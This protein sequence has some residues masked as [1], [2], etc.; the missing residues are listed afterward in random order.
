MS[1]ARDIKFI[2]VS[3]LSDQKKGTIFRA[4]K[5]VIE[6]YKGK[7]HV[8]DEMAFNEYNNPVHTILADNE[9]D[10]LRQEVEKCGTRMNITA[11]NEHVPE[12]ERQNRVI[13][14]RARAIIQTLPYKNLPR[15]IQIG[16]IY[17]VVYW[18]NNIPK[19]GQDYSPRDLVFGEQKLDYNNICKMP[20]GSYVQVH[21][22]L[23]IT[24]T[25]EARTIGAIDLGPTGNAEGTHK[26][27]SLKTGEILVRRKWNELPV[28]SDV[29]DRLKELTTDQYR[30][31]DDIMEQC[32]EQN[33]NENTDNLENNFE[34]S[35]E[36]SIQSEQNNF[37]KMKVLRFLMMSVVK[38]NRSF[39]S[40]IILIQIIIFQ[41]M[42]KKMWMN[43]VLIAKIVRKKRR[44]N[45]NTI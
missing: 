31:G 5:A 33:E 43:F 39:K 2:M 45:I 42:T 18:L 28:P 8:V 35:E 16:L 36:K 20:F 44:R 24:N 19:A 10:A 23:E 3:M 40:W 6:I 32:P 17:Y 22:D 7:G 4:I 37:W 34:L 41:Q 27:F 12:V 29:I 9:F 13:K 11:K 25:M 30:Y 21:D 1:V 26:F 14:E 15:K 38:M